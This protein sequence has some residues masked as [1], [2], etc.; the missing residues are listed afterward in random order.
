[1]P[2]NLQVKLNLMH[3]IAE[4]YVPMF[5]W[6]ILGMSNREDEC[7]DTLANTHIKHILKRGRPEEVNIDV[8]YIKRLIQNYKIACSKIKTIEYF[9]FQENET[10]GYEKVYEYI[11]ANTCPNNNLIHLKIGIKLN[12]PLAKMPI[13]QHHDDAGLDLFSINDVVLHPRTTTAIPIG[14][15]VQL[16]QGTYGAI[17]GRSGLAKDGIDVTGGVVDAGY[18]GDLC[19]YLY[20]SSEFIKELPSGSRVAQLVCIRI[21]YPEPIQIVEQLKKTARGAN[22]FGSTGSK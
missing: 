10:T 1:M 17:C 11:L 6:I 8:T 21:D 12:H 20:N 19:V 9:P 15:A 7:I 22:G 4:S 3:S 18:T 2:V 13:R 16:P 5:K 14:I